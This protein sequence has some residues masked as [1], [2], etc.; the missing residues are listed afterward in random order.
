MFK[1]IALRRL[2]KDIFVCAKKSVTSIIRSGTP[3][4]SG[5]K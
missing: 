2:K 3:G 1:K 4:V 5:N